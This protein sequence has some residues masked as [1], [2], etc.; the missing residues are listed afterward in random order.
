M[1]E[2]IYD[3]LYEEM[4]QLIKDLNRYT[5]FYNEGNPVISDQEWDKRYF[6]LV[7]LEHDL[8]VY[9]PES[10]TQSIAYTSVDKLK[11]VEHNH[12]ML[13]LDKTKNW[14][15]FLQYFGEHSVIGMIKCDGLTC[16]LRYVDGKLVSAETRGN[17]IKGEDIL[18]NALIIK[19]IPNK[20]DYDKELIVD[21]EVICDIKTFEEKFK[22]TY[23]NTRN[24][25]SGSIRLL[26]SKECD[27]RDLKF[28][29]W[30][31]VKGIDS[32]SFLQQLIKLD[33]LGFQVVPWTSSFAWDAK[34]FLIERAKEEGIPIDGLVGR[35]DD[36][37]YG[38]SLGRTDKFSKAAYAFKFADE[39]YETELLDIEW[40]MGRT[41]QLTP[42][43]V[44]K[45][46]DTGDSIIERAS[47]HNISIM[48]DIM[49]N[50]YY[51]QQITIIK[52]NMI[53]PQVIKGKRSPYDVM[54]ILYPDKC[55][56]CGG[57]VIIKKDNNSEFLYCNNPLCEGK[58]LNQLDHYCG[59]KGLD[60]KGLS[61][62]TLEK[63]IDWEWINSPADLY[64][65]ERYRKEW[66]N[67]SGFGEKSVDNILSAIEES[68]KVSFV[69]FISA[70]GIPMIGTTLAKELAKEFNNYNEF[71]KA[72]GNKYD[73]AQI[74]KIGEEKAKAILFFDYTDADEIYYNYLTEQQIETIELNSNLKDKKIVITGSL[75]LYTNRGE[76]QTVIENCGGSVTGSVS[77]NTSILI[78]NDIKSISSKN[79]K[80]KELGIPIMTEQEFYDTYLKN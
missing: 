64:R 69:S 7:Q 9:L 23:A 77:K 16:S 63:L 42:V 75:K 48:K 67:K 65:L 40:T 13:S 4:L 57:D 56:V 59:K 15:E 44:F 17:G 62:A 21:G 79:Q 68:K 37:E 61:K 76:L 39:E 51:H 29:A 60:I 50:P 2:E 6:R 36:I 49:G 33:K 47:L 45:P 53:I 38:E 14:N 32:N 73:F 80:A 41:G 24:F 5:I 19:N 11:E 22:D 74:N 78:N 1:R 52:S 8:Q 20:I 30:R 58:F 43:A 28:I 27:S 34:E 26:N 25:A 10:P 71:R 70:I 66:I 72:V 12:P 54:Y 3:K 46:I 18:H 55:P 31:A 35:F